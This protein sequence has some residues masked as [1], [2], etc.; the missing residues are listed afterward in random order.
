MQGGS[1]KSA[2]IRR[3]LAQGKFDP[4]KIGDQWREPMDRWHTAA[5]KAAKHSDAAKAAAAPP[6]TL[7]F[8][9]DTEAGRKAH[10]KTLKAMRRR[11][12]R[13]ARGGA[14]VGGSGDIRGYPA[15]AQLARAQ[16]Y[17]R[18]MAGR[19]RPNQGFD[20]PARSGFDE[21]ASGEQDAQ[22]L[23][24]I[25]DLVE[26]A[27]QDTATVSMRQALSEALLSHASFLSD[28][29]LAQVVQALGDSGL[30]QGV[31]ATVEQL[32]RRA[33]VSAS[34]RVMLLKHALKLYREAVADGRD[35]YHS[36]MTDP[37]IAR[38]VPAQHQNAYVDGPL[39]APPNRPPGYVGPWWEVDAPPVWGDGDDFEEEDR[40]GRVYNNQQEIDLR[41][42]FED[43][44]QEIDL[45]RLF[46]DDDEQEDNPPL[47]PGAPVAEGNLDADP[48]AAQRRHIEQLRASGDPAH[49]ALAN[50]LERQ[51]Q[52]NADDAAPEAADPEA[53]AAVEGAENAEF[54]L[55]AVP[56]PPLPTAPNS[57]EA[58]VAPLPGQGGTQGDGPINAGH[59]PNA[60]ADPVQ[61]TIAEQAESRE[62]AAGGPE[63]VTGANAIAASGVGNATDAL[64]SPE[65]AAAR[66]RLEGTTA[67][68]APPGFIT[69]QAARAPTE[70]PPVLQE[71]RDHYN[72]LAEHK[73]ELYEGLAALNERDDIAPKEQERLVHE[74]MASIAETDTLMAQVISEIQKA[75]GPSSA[76]T[77][78]RSTPQAT[79]SARSAR[80]STASEIVRPA[81]NTANVTFLRR[82]QGRTAAAGPAP[83]PLRGKSAGVGPRTPRFV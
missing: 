23:Q 31:L 12:R 20:G 21:L 64:T 59:P 2:Y 34:E 45:R 75:L 19:Q 32:A 81:G 56:P 18:A 13:A 50:L 71:L 22:M 38:L 41:H 68:P 11:A 63:T 28:A 69:P 25:L 3:L 42:L 7:K 58:L 47:P 46:E 83:A 17:M 14:L 65:A 29:S 40:L 37:A 24:D 73:D 57:A 49:Q 9:W 61:E 79:G 55:A 52:P 48:I 33:N 78:P 5:L 36:V 62:A 60:N 35:G 10:K 27:E 43:D 1:A 53:A 66:R 70:V 74:V 72:D 54:S 16:A 80:L 67:P 39:Q 26:Q 76:A 4:D 77:A 51:L 44:E 30:P 6:P 15:E 82:G 8:W